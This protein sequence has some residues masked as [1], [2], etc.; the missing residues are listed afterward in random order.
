MFAGKTKINNKQSPVAPQY[1]VFLNIIIEP[2]KT[3]KKPDKE[4]KKVEL[5]IQGGIITVKKSGLTK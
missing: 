5:G 4:T 1:L 3:S 2:N